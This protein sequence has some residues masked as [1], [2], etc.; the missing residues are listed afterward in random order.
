MY[1]IIVT[2]YFFRTSG[3]IID[4]VDV[5]CHLGEPIYA[6]IEGE[7]Y[8]WRPYGGKREKSCADQGVRIEGTGQWQGTFWNFKY[9]TIDFF[10]FKAT[11]CTYLLLNCPFSEGM[12]KLEMRLE[13]L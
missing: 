13:K 11:Q 7:M 6:P 12:L 1:V 4:G 3:E 10:K 5:R 9:K 2:T 8:F